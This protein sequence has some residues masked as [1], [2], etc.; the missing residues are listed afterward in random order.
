MIDLHCH[1]LPGLD[2]G[3]DDLREAMRMCDMAAADGIETIVATPHN[4][5]GLYG[6]DREKIMDAVSSFRE[7]ASKNGLRLDILPGADTHM[8][9]ELYD[10]IEKGNITTI[11][12]RGKF[13]LLEPPQF[14]TP[15]IMKEQIFRL[16]L[17]GLTPVITHPERIEALTGDFD[18][19]YEMIEAGALMQITAGSLTGNFGGD[20]KECALRMLRL[21]AVH[22]IAS[23]AHNTSARP[24]V[25]SKARR[26]TADTVGEREA[27]K[28]F[29]H[30]PRAIIEGIRPETSEPVRKKRSFFSFLRPR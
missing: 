21:N 20:I 10:E 14:I 12:D 24:P 5:N 28:L 29:L 13:L 16:R 25:L 4:L 1:I 22:V 19:L 18:A 11:N 2:D 3:P 26:L 30:N 23:D 8:A 17:G 15:E 7:I 27:D 9:A 6:N